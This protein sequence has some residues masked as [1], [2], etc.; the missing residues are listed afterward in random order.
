MGAD[1]LIKRSKWKILILGFLK[2]VSYLTVCFNDLKLIRLSTVSVDSALEC[3]GQS[4]PV[5]LRAAPSHLLQQQLLRSDPTP[6]ALHHVTHIS[7]THWTLCASLLRGSLFLHS[8]L[9]QSLITIVHLWR[10]VLHKVMSIP[11]TYTDTDARLCIY[12]SK[13]IHAKSS[14]MVEI[15]ISVTWIYLNRFT[16]MICSMIRSVALPADCIIMPVCDDSYCHWI[17]H[18]TFFL[19]H[20]VCDW[21]TL[22]KC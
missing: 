17:I 14:A 15:L 3:G 1:H 7:P 8:M 13:P 18:S 11:P 21:I 10:N 22:K 5:W 4:E 2:A 6:H 12:I 9:A 16:R 20:C 19:K